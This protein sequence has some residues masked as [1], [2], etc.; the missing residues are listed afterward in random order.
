M[1][2]RHLTHF[3]LL[4]AES[5]GT[6]LRDV[7]GWSGDPD[8]RAIVR[9]VG[10]SQHHPSRISRPAIREGW[11]R[12]GPGGAGR[13]DE[14]FIEVDWDEALDL[15]A[16]ELRR[17]YAEG[18]PSAVYGGSYGWSSAGRFHHGQS[19]VHRF[20][21]SLGG[22]VA[23]AGDYSYGTS[24]VLLPHVLGASPA[25]IMAEATT[26]EV[27]RDHTELFVSFGG[28]S[29]KNSAVGPGGIAK[30]AT[31]AGVQEA[32]DAGCR[33]VDISPIRD[34][35]FAEASTQWIAARPGSDA[36]LMLAL[37]HVLD[38]ESLADRVFLERFTV[39]YER[40][41]AY[42]RGETDGVPK[43]PRW[44]S[45]LTEVASSTIEDLARSMA[46]SRTMIN[47]SWSMQRQHHGEQPIWLGV[48][49]A[50]MIGQIGLPGGGFQ[51]GYGSS[52]DVGLARR[53]LSPP[54]LPTGK[55]AETSFI[56]VAR[57]ADMLLHPGDT[58]DYNGRKVTL[59]EIDLVYWVG[60]NPFHHH[61]DLAKLRQ[62]FKMPS[63]VVVHEQFWTSTARHADFVLPAT[64]S[65]ERD[66]YGSGRNDPFFFPMPAMTTPAGEA[67]DDFSIFA[68][69]E[70]RLEIDERFSEGRTARQW[71]RHLYENWAERMEVLGHAVPDFEDFWTSDHLE[72]P[73][74]DPRQVL[75]ADFRADPVAHPLATPSGLIEIHSSTI[76][77]FGYDDCPG[78]PVWLEPREWLGTDDR[79]H[80][81]HLISN[82]P[83]TR[84]HSQLDVG[85]TSQRSKINGREPARMNPADAEARGLTTGDT[86]LLRNERGT[87]L[88]GLVVSE[89]IR[90]GIVQLATGAWYDP[91]PDDPSFCRHGNPN[92]LTAD[93]PSS[94]LSQGTTAQHALIEVERW[95]GPLPPLAV[96]R[97]PVLLPRNSASGSGT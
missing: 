69:L 86:I 56:P 45:G 31:R 20:L 42:V 19:Q 8:P 79:V 47:L 66:D 37:A 97:S 16:G 28:L 24:G 21:N 13:G 71:L 57:I 89:E 87:C 60:G 93:L 75:H 25:E 91:D 88:A 72:I 14:P 78:H 32:R 73:V 15:L 83:K 90:L 92:V 77:A 33:F 40:F 59:P 3:G 58:I 5:D 84:L 12:N 81:L 17:V 96:D 50:A 82:Q 27:I 6:S 11:L 53:V 10:S 52:A 94:L 1:R 48:T 65:I 7:T 34:D 55:N 44:A 35:S 9:N 63:T 43:S 39:G 29:E 51:H 67:R 2:S 49:L 64:M 76:E 26:W 70:S 74:A 4:E 85:E 54:A 68:A 62:A 30:H 61:Q 23:G 41:I 22:Y 38:A 46:R 80:P 95:D 36:A 18:G